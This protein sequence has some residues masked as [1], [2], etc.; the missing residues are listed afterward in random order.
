MSLT[1]NL[2]RLREGR[3]SLVTRIQGRKRRE[4]SVFL[5]KLH[6]DMHHLISTPTLKSY[7]I[8]E[9]VKKPE[10]SKLSFNKTM[11]LG[12]ALSNSKARSW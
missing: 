9:E 1:S 4:P 8:M 3:L 5:K 11:D 2:L 6:I 7:L 10:E 12:K